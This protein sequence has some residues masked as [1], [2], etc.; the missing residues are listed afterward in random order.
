MR[1][2][3]LE[4]IGPSGA[5]VHIDAYGAGELLIESHAGQGMVLIRDT[6]LPPYPAPPPP[7]RPLAQVGK[8]KPQPQAAPAHP[9]ANA[10][11]VAQ[12]PLSW[13][14]F[15]Y[16]EH[17]EPPPAGEPVELMDPPPIVA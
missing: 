10:R 9:H 12:M 3:K 17:T 15:P 2:G 7:S 4:L 11:I 13:A 1:L 5:Q 6:G 16:W 8:N 14:I